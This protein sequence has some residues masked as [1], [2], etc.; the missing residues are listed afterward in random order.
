M[1]N[2]RN[3]A[4]QCAEIFIILFLKYFHSILLLSP[5]LYRFILLLSVLLF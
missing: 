3:L 1:Y 2:S 5:N 4:G